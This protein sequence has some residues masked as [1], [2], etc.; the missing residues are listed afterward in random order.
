MSLP[1][2]IAQ[3]L[4][5]YLETAG[6]DGFVFGLSGGVDSAT[7]A[8]L[9]VRAVGTDRV[10]A[11]LMPCH[12]QP[13]DLRLAQK[14]ADTFGIP[15]VTIDLTPIY[16]ALLATL[17]PSENALAPANIKPRLRMITLYYL[18]QSRNYLVLGSGNKSERN[19][20]YFCYDEQTRALTPEGLKTFR[21]LQPGDVVFSLDLRDAKVIE[22]PVAGVYTFEYEG[23]MLAYGGEKRRSI[24]LMVT[25]NHR[26]LIERQGQ[27]EFRRADELPRR[28]TPLPLPC[29]WEGSGTPP[30]VF[31]FDNTDIGPN[32]RRFSPMP[33]DEF[34]YILGLYIGDG[35]AQ[36]Y[37]VLQPVK[38]TGRKRDPQTG[39]FVAGEAET[40]LVQYTG[41]R[42]WFALPD[43]SKGRSRLIA[44]LEKN[45][46]EWGATPIEV[47]VS[48]RPFYQAMVECGTSAKEKQIPLWVMRYPAKYLAHLLEGLMDSD[49]DGNG[50]YYTSSRRLAEQ[51]AELGCKTARNIV[52]RVRPPRTAVRRDGIPVRSGIS[53][54]V[55]IYGNGR[56]WLNGAKFRR[57]PYK[58]IVWCPDVPE[59]HNLLVERN[60][61]FLFCG[62]TKYGDGGVDLLPLGGL[63]KTQVWE[64]ARELGVPQEVIDRPPSAGLWPGQTDEGEMGITYRELDRV[65]A[66]LEAGDL[67]GLD[68]A[69]VEK[70]RGMM[71]RSEHKRRMPPVFEP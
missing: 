52:L 51:V 54:E 18:A 38:G 3:W 15:T 61:K 62:N 39:R 37:P 46:I 41:Y 57:V 11:A 34:L 56:R 22:R 36:T 6:A 5:D 65:L 69:A 23:E 21:E 60:G 53:Y 67:S 35:H 10:L 31:E 63:Y 47:W 44:I 66:A 4:R 48:G 19:V 12:S 16:D 27:L 64:L 17:P 14:V 30:P 49:G 40:T 24:D 33:M 71:A 68:P 25:P 45:G 42:T 26:I 43:G 8:A 1:D 2:R 9:A 32:A 13:E 58:G 70:V 28:P 59:T 55:R 7:S 29:P 50:C 20:G